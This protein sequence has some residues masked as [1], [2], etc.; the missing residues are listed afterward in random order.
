MHLPEIIDYPVAAQLL[1]PTCMLRRFTK[2][3]LVT[4]G[5]GLSMMGA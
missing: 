4:F 5:A 3:K 1:P 2:S